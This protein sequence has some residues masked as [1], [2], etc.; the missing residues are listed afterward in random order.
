MEYPSEPKGLPPAQGLYSPQDEHSSC[1]VGFVADIQGRATHSLL[2]QGLTAGASLAHRGAVSADGLTADGAGVLTQLPRRLLVRELQRGGFS[3]DPLDV[4]A[5]M[6]FFPRAHLPARDRGIAIVEEE[7]RRA[8]IPMLMWREVPVDNTALGDQARSVE[9]IARQVLMRRPGGLSDDEF[10]RA[11]YLC[12]RRIQKRV[13]QAGCDPFYLCSFSSRTIVYKGLVASTKLSAYFRDLADPE[14][15][16]AICVFHQRFSTNTFPTW[17]LA[18]PFRM[19]AHNG[20]FNTLRGNINWLR[21]RQQSLTSKTFGEALADLLPVVN[22]LDSDSATFDRVLELLTMCGRDPLRVLTML[23][24]EAHQSVTDLGDDVRAMHEYHSTLMEPWDGPAALVF[25]D[26]RI[27]A[28]ALDRNGLRPMRYWVTDSGVVIAGSETGLVP[29][30]P[31]RIVEKG[32]LAPG[33]LFAVDTVRHELL[34]NSEI[35]SRLA[36]SLPFATWLEHNRVRA[37]RSQIDPALAPVEPLAAQPADLSRLQRAFGY[38]TED[39][40]RLLSPLSQDPKPPLG[41]MGD[42]TPIAVLS[43]KPQSLYRYFKQRF[44]Q[45]TNPPV[46]SI[47]EE[48]AMSIQTAIGRRENLLEDSEHAA[49][50]IRFSSPLISS[51]ELAWLCEREHDG[52]QAV[53]LDASYEVS[54]GTAAIEAALSTLTDR[55]ESAVDHGACLI[56]LED[57]HITPTRAAIPMLLAVAALQQHLIRRGKR[58]L[59]SIIADTCEAREDHHFAC[60][61]GFGATLIHPRLAFESVAALSDPEKVEQALTNYKTGIEKGILKIMAKMGIAVLHSYR[62]AQLFEAVGVSKQLIDRHFEGTSHRLGGIGMQQIAADV[63]SFHA[64]AFR[65]ATGLPDRG[66]YRYRQGG[67]VHANAPAVFT[68]LHKAVRTG[69][70]ELFDQFSAKADA[71]TPTR[72]RDLLRPVGLGPAIPLDEVESAEC[73]ARRFTTQAMS[74]GALSREAHELMAVA[75]NRLGGRSNSGEGG[76]DSSRFRRYTATSLPQ[77]EGAWRPEDGDW[78]CSTIKQVSTA[79]FGVTPAYLVSAVE[80][81]IKMAQGA[82][83]GEGG[84]IPGFK[85]NAEIAALRRAAVG[86]TLISPP[87][88]HDIYSIEDLAQLIYDLKRVSRLAK[89]GVKLV[90][91]TGVGAIAAGVAKA[92]ADIIQISGHEGGTGASPLGSIKHAGIPW[93]LGLAEAQQVLVKNDLRGRV[94][95]RVDGGLRT[96]RDVVL[97]ALLG[98]DEFGFATTALL[99]AGCVMARQCHSNTCPVGIAT[100]RTD[101]RAKFPGRPEHVIRLMLYVAEQVRLM[102]AD[103][104]ARSLDDI[105]G[106][107]DLLRVSDRAVSPKGCLIDVSALL[108]DPDP[109]GTHARRNILPRNSAPEARTPLDELVLGEVW[110]VIAAGGVAKGSYRISNL[111]R[112]VGARLA[113]EIA[114]AYGESGLKPETISLEFQGVAG[115]SFGAFCTHGMSLTLRG[116]AQD[117]VGKSMHGGRIVIAQP[118]AS[119]VVEHLSTIVGN[120]VLYGATG[121]EVFI[122]GRAGERCCVRNSGATV[123]IEGCGDHGCEYMT[124]G[125]VVVLGIF[126]RNFGAGMSGGRAFVLDLHGH[127]P[128]VLNHEMVQLERVDRDDDR[129][130]LRSLIERHK[131]FTQSRRARDLL[132]EWDDVIPKFWLVVPKGT[133][134]ASLT[135]PA[136]HGQALAIPASDAEVVVRPQPLSLHNSHDGPPNSANA[137]T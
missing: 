113:G 96:G 16:T 95:L 116:D 81:E 59:A 107:T 67:E 80:L 119:Q 26:G 71:A 90:S 121:G 53:R 43:E 66:V 21:A 77:L 20:E 57:W 123:V 32:R 51:R 2:V 14:Y 74:H 137:R 133:S 106:R 54:G 103:L 52:F 60:L 36:K 89:I 30:D 45:V 127:L 117:Y 19:I 23:V 94:R 24:P 49:R 28:A 78:A 102:L 61:L 3:I 114:R 73:I 92:F 134:P 65:D 126:G 97:A 50:L 136:A 99:A 62:G 82:K 55:A 13:A 132:D 75:M 42:D 105:I 93:E 10:E 83:P 101:L 33:G 110:P 85:V 130:E 44:A 38:G 1:G 86:T 88:H 84:Q 5:G 25:S 120:T 108:V 104:G 6:I 70:R 31:A 109:E 34:H 100:Q 48:A 129:R 18:Q 27:A 11:L 128:D 46:D 87:P 72:V 39:L 115:Q 9:P 47:R 15:E 4:A 124:A 98:A 64:D 29:V 7:V 125:V 8:G 17:F 35:K 135:A 122:A 12:R 69:S 68:A 58:L 76:E 131:E 79:R 56:I 22:A 111:D 40:E 118:V 41:S 63:A 91:T 112:T 37:D